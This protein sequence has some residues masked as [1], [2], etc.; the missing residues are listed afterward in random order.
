MFFK[1][2]F[3]LFIKFHWIMEIMI[4]M[5]LLGWNIILILLIRL[6]CFLR[7]AYSLHLF[8]IQVSHGES[9]RIVKNGFDGGAIS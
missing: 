5:V 3:P 4:T 9:F 2:F 7:L 6:I 8:S 1:F